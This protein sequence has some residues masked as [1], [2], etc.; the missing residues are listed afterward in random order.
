MCYMPAR[1]NAFIVILSKQICLYQIK[2]KLMYIYDTQILYDNFGNFGT[3]FIVLQVQISCDV[4]KML[5]S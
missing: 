2:L 5:S 3:Q 4:I 1:V